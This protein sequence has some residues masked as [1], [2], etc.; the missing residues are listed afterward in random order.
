M[1]GTADGGLRTGDGELGT[2]VGGLKSHQNE[3]VTEKTG[4]GAYGNSITEA[5]S[6][7]RC[8]RRVVAVY[9]PARYR[10]RD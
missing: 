6:T 3:L 4:L 5:V 9:R 7:A 10:R 1:D 8:R 2:S